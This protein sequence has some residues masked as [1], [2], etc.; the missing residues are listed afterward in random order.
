[1]YHV[2]RPTELLACCAS[3]IKMTRASYQ[4]TNRLVQ[5]FY[6]YIVALPFLLGC[7]SLDLCWP[8]TTGDLWSAHFNV[9]FGVEREGEFRRI[10]RNFGGAFDM[11]RAHVAAGVPLMRVFLR[12][13]TSPTRYYTPRQLPTKVSRSL[14]TGTQ[15]YFYTS[16]HPPT[17]VTKISA[18][19]AVYNVDHL[20]NSKWPTSRQ[21]LCLLARNLT[22]HVT[23]CASLY[24]ILI[25]FQD[26]E[27]ESRQHSLLP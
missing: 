12:V 15:A 25:K 8:L 14:P 11:A 16:N 4:L 24:K 9:L 2:W 13:P 21:S 18:S 20:R 17:C 6:I 1:M 23:T 3:D 7:L 19:Q 26:A 5:F 10:A 27:I 22:R